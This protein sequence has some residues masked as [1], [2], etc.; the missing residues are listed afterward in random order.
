MYPMTLQ[1]FPIAYGMVRLSQRSNQNY[2]IRYMCFWSAFN[3]IYQY[4]SDQD[5]FG[6]RLVYDANQQ[7]RIR[8]V[9]GYLLP[10]VET[11]P[12]TEAILRTIR[13][14]SPEQR[15]KWL[16][17]PEVLFFVERT[18]EGAKGVSCPDRPGLFDRHGQR[19]NGVLNR[20]RTVDSLH[21]YYAP[22]D[23]E[24]YKAFLE[25]DT[26]HTEL[27]TN[28][29]ALLLYTVRNNLMYGHKEI[30]SNNDS[31]LVRNAYPLLEYLVRCFV[32]FPQK[33]STYGK[34]NS[35]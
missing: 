30:T 9:T 29:L 18:P 23:M 5:G 17:L 3:N 8:E 4:L 14:L 24:K 31:E 26:S 21:P 13:K 7:L 2:F 20:T 6:S 34:L 22:I 33:R 32:N 28:Q 19:I 15:I 35:E 27:L 12:E 11:E 10:R 25:G 1:A 16:R